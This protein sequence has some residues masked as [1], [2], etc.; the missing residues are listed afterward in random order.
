ME[1]SQLVW[2]ELKHSPPVLIESK[3]VEVVGMNG[4]IYNVFGMKW[5]H[6]QNFW[7]EM[8]NFHNMFGMKWKHLEL[9]GN[10]MERFRACLE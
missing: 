10:K 1:H 8:E 2:N 4:N 7:N 9:F 3:H 5:K 6:S